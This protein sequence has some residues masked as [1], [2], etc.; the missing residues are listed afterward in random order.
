MQRGERTQLICLQILWNV[1]VI[2][3]NNT[4]LLINGY[5]C[6]KNITYPEE[7][8]VMLA[9]ILLCSLMKK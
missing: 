3:R 1:V 9:P 4:L 5:Q 7:K 2:K 8:D 6:N